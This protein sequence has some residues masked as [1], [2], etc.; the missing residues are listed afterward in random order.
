MLTRAAVVAATL[1]AAG[2]AGARP[3]H[4]QATTMP[5]T[6]RY[7]SGL[8]DVPV[9]SVLPHLMT[10]GTLSG[11][12]ID[13]SQRVEVD[14]SGAPS[15]YGPGVDELFTDA[16]FAV[17]LFDRAE[18]GV[19][20]QAFGDE[21]SGGD[22]WG[23][24]GRVRVWQPIDQGLGLAVGGRWLT[25]P[26]FPGGE[27][28]APGRLG[29]ADERLRRS[30]TGSVDGVDTDLS[31]YAVGTAFIRGFDGGPLPAN[32]LTFTLG[33]G[34]GMFDSGDDLAFHAP[35]GDGNGWFAGTSIAV[36]VTERSLLT[37]MA[38][39][40]GF[41]V[42]VGAHFDWDGLRVGAQ[43]LA[44]NHDWPDIGQVSE[45]QKPKLGLLASIALCPGQPRLRCRPRRMERLEPDT[46]RIP[47]P[48]PDTV[49]VTRGSTEPP[50]GEDT[51][52]CLSTGQPVPIRITA[53]GDTLVAPSYTSIRALRP[54]V[55]FAGGYASGTFWYES[56]QPVRFEGLDYDRSPDT[57][58]LE[59]TQVLRVGVYEGVPVF[60]VVSA[61][62]PLDVLFIPVRP[63]LWR[64]Y[65]V[66]RPE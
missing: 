6:L 60:A 55:D 41:D 34:T 21:G 58:P 32:D 2:L 39:H 27:R 38:E 36:E 20:L 14:E 22:I 13:L 65:V 24:F 49:I 62:R 29:F 64:R 18:V 52:L 31:L 1:A 11:F 4:A 44:T 26:S 54:T 35:S 12:W 37:L 53:A 43:Y 7:G 63:G 51:S 48:P 5:S 56:G 3:A 17:G 57:F 61:E 19:S 59:C 50:P 47:A 8:M 16:A 40:N 10:T 42:N 46:I 15:G 30:Y 45:Y 9:S 33:F 66:R 23:L 25:S 28:H